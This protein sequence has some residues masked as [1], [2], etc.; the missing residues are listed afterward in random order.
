MVSW[1]QRFRRA[2]FPLLVLVL[3]GS[4]PMGAVRFVEVPD[5][6]LPLH[7]YI[8]DVYGLDVLF[9]LQSLPGRR[10]YAI[11]T[12][13]VIGRHQRLAVGDPIQA[14]ELA[15]LDRQLESW[16]TLLAEGTSAYPSG[17][18]KMA[19]AAR[20]GR[21][22]W[23]HFA[24]SRDKDWPV[25]EQTVFEVIRGSGGFVPPDPPSF[26]RYFSQPGSDALFAPR[27]PEPQGLFAPRLPEPD[28]HFAPPRTVQRLDARVRECNVVWGPKGW[29]AETSIV[30]EI[31][32][33]AG[34]V[35]T[36]EH[37]QKTA[38]ELDHD[39]S[40]R[41]VGGSWQSSPTG[42]SLGRLKPPVA[43]VRRYRVVFPCD[44]SLGCG[45]TYREAH[46]G[47]DNVGNRVEIVLECSYSQC[48][49]P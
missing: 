44:A 6:M 32:I 5:T 1:C 21:L 42:S 22:T 43:E 30:F 18:S 16:L 47:F 40:G 45:G 35:V 34:I 17:F 13:Y 3:F 12:G 10:D 48:R 8:G 14:Q 11:I 26:L 25:S 4:V 39:G 24:P 37:G 36:M 31:L 28:G 38:F 19:H 15:T 29:R 23:G 9:L 49:H 41:V 2:A 46:T 7:E 27:L 20:D 33:P